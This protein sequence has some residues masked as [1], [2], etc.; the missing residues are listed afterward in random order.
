MVS[1]DHTSLMPTLLLCPSPL[2]RMRCAYGTSVLCPASGLP[3]AWLRVSHTLSTRHL[4]LPYSSQ[5]IVLEGGCYLCGEALW[6]RDACLARM[7][8]DDAA[9]GACLGDSM[10]RA[11][12]DAARGGAAHEKRAVLSLRSSALQGVLISRHSSEVS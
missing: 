10:A 9:P 4:V 6:A 12:G 7:A 3:C 11:G 8:G 1:K 5:C 2:P